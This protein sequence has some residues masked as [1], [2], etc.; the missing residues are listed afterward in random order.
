MIGRVGVC[1]WSL[2]P[3]SPKALAERLGAIGAT[4]VQLALGPM[5]T[6]AWSVAGTTAALRD[7]G[8]TILS[9]MMATE[10]EDYSTLDTIRQTGGVRPDA[11]WNMNKRIAETD[12]D[13][14]AELGLSLVTFHAGF[15]PHDEADPE[16]GVL[17]DRLREVI[18]LFADR[19]VRV[20]FETGQETAHT[21]ERALDQLQR[22]TAGV[23]FD[24]ANMIL[25][26]MGDPIEAIRTLGPRIV[27][28]HVK[29][30]VPTET[31][32]TWGAEM[33][34][35]SGAVDWQ[36][37][38]DSIAALP[39]RVDLLVEREAGGARAGDID[40]ALKLIS[41]YAAGGK[42]DER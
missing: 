17:M 34:A 22:P 13:I 6:G 4:G 16:R 40:V 2:Q 26:G 21:L 7:A 12:A 39:Q 24:P 29:D 8:I 10:G 19:G 3:K 25:Y 15:I 20:G 35:G 41:K 11:H 32:G 38:F 27:Q 9:G 36:R 5:R 1:S 30:A 42:A 31:P 33:A 14:A 18:D 28:A 37:F 23:N